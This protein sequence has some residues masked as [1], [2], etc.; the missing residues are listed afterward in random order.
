[1]VNKFLSMWWVKRCRFRRSSLL[2]DQ[3]LAMCDK[4]IFISWKHSQRKRKVGASIFNL[5]LTVGM[6][7][8]HLLELLWGK[9]KSSSEGSFCPCWF[10]AINQLL[11]FWHM[12]AEQFASAHR[13]DRSEQFISY[14]PGVLFVVRWRALF[15]GH[16][17][18]VK[19]F[20]T[21][22]VAWV[23]W[24]S[25]EYDQMSW[26]EPNYQSWEVRVVYPALAI[27]GSLYQ[28]WMW[29]TGTPLIC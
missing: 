13:L 14:V 17:T 27:K 20:Q 19:V 23:W 24:G 18:I 1:M 6:F 5:C 10:S 4:N 8:K 21:W 3:A 15:V 11:S 28:S 25:K 16:K 26:V 12:L 2:T 7:S 9:D 29:I 22:H